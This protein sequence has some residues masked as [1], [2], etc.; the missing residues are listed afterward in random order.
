M[1]G[2]AGMGLGEMGE[3][4]ELVIEEGIRARAVMV[5]R[6]EMGMGVWGM[7]NCRSLCLEFGWRGVSR[8]GG[9]CEGVEG[10]LMLFIVFVF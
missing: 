3:L 10:S 1:E 4:G 6:M 5:L 9:V 8:P 7:G 2:R